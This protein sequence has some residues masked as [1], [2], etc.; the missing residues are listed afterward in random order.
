MTLGLIHGEYPEL[1]TSY[2]IVFRASNLPPVTIWLWSNSLSSE[3][4]C[5]E[6]T[7]VSPTDQPLTYPPSKIR[8]SRGKEDEHDPDWEKIKNIIKYKSQS[9]SVL[10]LPK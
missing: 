8:Q 7:R 9:S 5:E 3:I 10:R 1:E 2:H 6:Q 4:W